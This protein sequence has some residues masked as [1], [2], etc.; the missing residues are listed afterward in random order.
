MDWLYLF[1]QRSGTYFLGLLALVFVCLIVWVF[2]AYLADIR[3]TAHTVRR[4]FPV[5]G[6][7]RYLFE[8]LGEFFQIVN[9]TYS[10]VTINWSRLWIGYTFLP[11]AAA[12]IF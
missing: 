5:I 9:S 2:F 4:N 3:Q 1:A 12:R 11:N 10:I 8:H 6:R 7:F